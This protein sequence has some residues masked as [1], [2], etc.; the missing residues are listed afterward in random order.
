MHTDYDVIIIGVRVA[1]SILAARLGQMGFT[2]LG[3]D[4]ATFPSDTLSTHFFRAPS[5]R[6]FAE[7][8]VLEKVKSVA[9]QLTINYNVIDGIAFPEAVDRPVDYPFYMCV[10]RIIL[11][12]IL[13]QRAREFSSVHI[14]EG[15]KVTDLLYQGDRVTGVKWKGKNGFGEAKARVIIGADGVRSF[16]AR[17]VKAQ[18]ELQE[19]VNRA[20]YY[21]YFS[22]FKAKE[23]PA[24][25][26]H[27]NG[28]LLVYSFPCDNNLTLLAVSVPISEFVNFKQDAENEFIRR[29]KLMVEIS[30]RLDCAR[31]ESPVNGTGSIPGYLRIPFGNGWALVGDSGMVMDPWSGQGIDQSST[32]ALL[33]AKHLV[34]YFSGTKWETAMQ[35]YHKERNEYSLKAFQRTCKFSADLR[36]MTRAALENRGLT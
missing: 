20:M 11:D 12:N 14:L 3:I 7:I 19:P 10:R 4:R 33:M 21:A 22:G 34:N 30:P 27:F 18:I 28:N 9:P 6:A 23:G 5:F 29:L 15:T 36:P 32:H 24:A 35:Q 2:V 26:F 16:I 17:E 8:G 25:E 13:V 1:G 31:R